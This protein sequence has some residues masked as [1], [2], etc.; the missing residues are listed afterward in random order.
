VGAA[1]IRGGRA[2]RGGDGGL[3]AAPGPRTAQEGGGGGV[4]RRARVHGGRS[5]APAKYEGRRRQPRQDRL[6]TS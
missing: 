2:A 1:R 4:P 3:G 5:R 6:M